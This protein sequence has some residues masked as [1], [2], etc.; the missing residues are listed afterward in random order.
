MKK[1]QFFS[2]LHLKLGFG[3]YQ[4]FLGTTNVESLATPLM[5]GQ[6]KMIQN[7]PRDRVDETE[8]YTGFHFFVTSSRPIKAMLK[9]VK[10]DNLTLQNLPE[11]REKENR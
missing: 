6:Q 8:V 11:G 10:I 3:H 2:I 9:V 1:G 4:Y 5:V 7:I